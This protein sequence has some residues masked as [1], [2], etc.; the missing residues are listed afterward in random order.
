MS[1]LSWMKALGLGLG[2]ATGVAAALYYH[3]ALRPL[4]RREGRVFLRGLD[5]PAEVLWDQWGVPHVYAQGQDDLFFLQGYLHAQDRLWQMELS[6][7]AGSGRL[8]EIFGRRTLETDRFL[9]RV[10]LHRAARA[11]AERL[12]DE[13]AAV[14]SSYCRGVSTFIRGRRDRLPLEFS[15]LRFR[16]EPWRPEDTLVWAKTLGWSL[17]LNWDTELYR[18]RMIQELGPELAARLEQ[19]YPEGHPLTTPPGA[20]EPLGTPP[21]IEG[22][23]SLPAIL[24]GGFS[25]AWAVS[26]RRS[27]TGKPLLANDPHLVPQLPSV[28][29]EMHLE[30]PTLRVSGASVPGVPGVVIGHNQHIAWGITASMVDTQDV[31][32][33]EFS[34]DAPGRYRLQDGWEEVSRVREEIRVKGAQ[35]PVV[36]EVWLTRHG[37]LIATPRAPGQRGLALRSTALDPGNLLRAG[38]ELA[39][40]SAWD[41]FSAALGHWSAPCLNFV[42]ADA[43][44]HIGYRLAGLTPRRPPESGLTPLPGWTGDQEWQGFLAPEELPHAFDPPEGFVV[45][46][47]NKVAGRNHAAYI[48]GEWIDGFRAQ[49]IQDLLQTRDTLGPAD[50]RTMHMDALSLPALELLRLLEGL[51]P[52]SAPARAALATLRA[53]DGR[54]EAESQAAALYEVFR[55]RLLRNLLAPALGPHIESYFGLR[56]HPLSVSS[57]YQFRGA[58]FLLE[59]VR[60]MGQPGLSPLTGSLTLEEAMSRSLEETLAELRQRLGPD[61]TRWDWGRLHQVTFSHALGEVPMLGWLLNRGPYPVPGDTDTVHQASYSLREPYGATRWLPSFRFIADTSDWDRCQSIHAPGQSGQPGSPH[62]DNLVSLWRRG[63][64]HPMPFSRPAVEAV[65]QTRQEY[66]PG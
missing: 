7:R 41:G 21:P 47:N 10:G 6:R 31:Y 65:A 33:E 59:L 29:Y 26:G 43:Q 54:V 32:V 60:G 44:G 64:Y 55:R 35:R 19:P 37:P 11:E 27:Q 14:L 30:C 13:S 52:T 16:P 63:E 5:A 56:L 9:R 1:N 15:L 66:L 23:E 38:L 40:A 18:A 57:A 2:L 34:P 58:S 62:Y 45:N 39:K 50:F 48:A 3:L 42:Y 25:N 28:W 53:W 36:E 22:W 49:R 4:P 20:T 24:R 51:R 61:P 46:G 12:D 17:S 8:S